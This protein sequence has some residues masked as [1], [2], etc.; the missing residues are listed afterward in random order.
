MQESKKPAVQSAGLIDRL[1]GA[2]VVKSRDP[3][4]NSG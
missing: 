3:E 4:I 1:A 2:K